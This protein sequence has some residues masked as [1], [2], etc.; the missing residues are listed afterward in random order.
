VLSVLS[1]KLLITESVTEETKEYDMDPF[2]ETFCVYTNVSSPP[3]LHMIFMS[4][5][6]YHKLWF[7]ADYPIHI[8]YIDH[9][10]DFIK[11]NLATNPTIR[12]QQHKLYISNQ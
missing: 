5:C 12:I 6:A 1:A 9:M 4:W 7:P 11:V 8:E 2:L 10:G 3:T